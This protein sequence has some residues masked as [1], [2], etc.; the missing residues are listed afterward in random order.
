MDKNITKDEITGLMS[1]KKYSVKEC[2]GEGSFGRVFDCKL[3]DNQHSSTPIVV[4]IVKAT[5]SQREIKYLQRI[6]KKIKD[7]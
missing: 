3:L 2:I 5:E 7:H 6:N 4:K 1:G